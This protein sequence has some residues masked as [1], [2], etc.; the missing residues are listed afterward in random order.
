MQVMTGLVLTSSPAAL[1]SRTR[2]PTARILTQPRL[3]AQAIYLNGGS[4]PC[5]RD[6][7]MVSLVQPLLNPF[8]RFLLLLLS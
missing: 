3:K 2:C 1:A 4:L 5:V 8:H 7:L 6:G